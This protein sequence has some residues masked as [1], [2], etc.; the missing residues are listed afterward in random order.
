VSGAASIRLPRWPLAFARQR[1]AGMSGVSVSR[2]E[3]S[4]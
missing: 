1:G 2:D 4:K 3:Q